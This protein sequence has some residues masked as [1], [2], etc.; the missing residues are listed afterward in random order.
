M[1]Y[2]VEREKVRVKAWNSRTK[3]EAAINSIMTGHGDC[4]EPLS[5]LYFSGVVYTV[6]SDSD[7]E[8]KFRD[9]FTMHYA[10]LV[11]E[12]VAKTTKFYND[13]MKETKTEAK[14]ENKPVGIS[15]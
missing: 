3:E 14:Y 5:D 4:C 8:L 10:K 1:E 6:P 9:A 7:F 13:K 11:R 12:W 2:L 15:L